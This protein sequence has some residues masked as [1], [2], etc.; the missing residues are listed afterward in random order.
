MS[1]ARERPRR[2]RQPLEIKI[3]IKKLICRS[4]KNVTPILIFNFFNLKRIV[5]AQKIANCHLP[6]RNK[7]VTLR[8]VLKIFILKLD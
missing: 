8:R 3:H 1:E 7:L 4:G 5:C 6:I 2:L